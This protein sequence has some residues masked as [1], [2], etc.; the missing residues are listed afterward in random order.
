VSSGD[1]WRETKGGLWAFL[2]VPLSSFVKR[3]IGKNPSSFFG[4]SNGIRRGLWFI[5]NLSCQSDSWLATRDLKSLVTLKSLFW[6]WCF[7]LITSIL[8]LLSKSQKF[9]LLSTG[10]ES[11]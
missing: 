7:D 2:L 4:L 6:R 11:A 3:L 5:E 10:L 9:W 8:E 1:E